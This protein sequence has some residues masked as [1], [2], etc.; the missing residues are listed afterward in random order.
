MP[1]AVTVYKTEDGCQFDD[2][3]TAVDHERLTFL[4]ESLISLVSS[5]AYADLKVMTADDLLYF[6]TKDIARTREFA[7]MF[8]YVLDK[9]NG[10]SR[11]AVREKR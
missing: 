7:A 5:W 10:R 6:L 2:M 8:R 4:R 1:T 3:Q 9:P 11:R